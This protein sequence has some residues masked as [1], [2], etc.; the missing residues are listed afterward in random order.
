MPEKILVV[1]DNQAMRLS[2]VRLLEGES[3]EVVQ[4]VDGED[5]LAKYA[6][7][8]PDLVIMDINMPRMNGL[9]AVR[10]LRE[11]SG[12]PILMLSVRSNEMDKVYGLN[13]G[14]D[15]YLA[16]PFGRDELLARIRALLRRHV[17][18][19]LA[20][21][22]DVLRLGGGELIIDREQQQVLLGGQ[23]V[24]LTPIESRLLFTLAER[25]GEVFTQ[26]QLLEAVWEGDPS[27]TSQNLKLY[28]LYL[29]RKI[30]PDPEEPRY[31]LTVRGVGYMLAAL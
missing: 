21:R 11:F 24:R 9:E 26:R 7:H 29:R 10:R 18:E 20:S 12:V 16:K 6:Q 31:L 19:R 23:L 1:E 8:S 30:E 2:L 13:V 25:P 4:A 28:I 27:G 22:R 17:H 5:A 14:A 3:Y 15:D